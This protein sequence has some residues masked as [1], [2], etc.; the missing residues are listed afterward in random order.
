MKEKIIELIL[1][2]E[3]ISAKIRDLSGQKRALENKI[4]KLIQAIKNEERP[5]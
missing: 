2:R 5:A 3:D 4:G 1:E